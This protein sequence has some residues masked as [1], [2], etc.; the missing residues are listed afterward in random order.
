MSYCSCNNLL[1]RIIVFI[2]GIDWRNFYPFGI[3]FLNKFL[4]TLFCI[5][6]QELGKFLKTFSSKMVA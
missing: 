5:I 3:Y 1:H 2:R 4:E 6:F